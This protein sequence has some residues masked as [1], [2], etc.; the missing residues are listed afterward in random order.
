MDMP[1]YTPVLYFGIGI[2]VG[3]LGI[4]G[5]AV[6][7]QKREAPAP[8]KSSRK[9][10]KLENLHFD[11]HYDIR[12]KAHGTYA[13]LMAE[14]CIVMAKQM[15]ENESFRKNGQAHECVYSVTIKGSANFIERPVTETLQ[16]AAIDGF[17]KA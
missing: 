11:Y 13:D 14:L 16:G 5:Y 2:A 10:T 9:W 6:W 12:A 15:R 7:M 3:V 17:P 4:L 1:T 8:Q